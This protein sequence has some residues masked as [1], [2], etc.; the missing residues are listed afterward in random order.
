MT[1]AMY[2]TATLRGLE[3]DQLVEL[4]KAHEQQA[5][6]LRAAAARRAEE[7][8]M[9]RATRAHFDTLAAAPALVDKYERQGSDRA[10]AIA[11]TALQLDVPGATV[12]AYLLKRERV[13]QERRKGDCEGTVMQLVSDGHSNAE[14]ARR[15]GAHPGTVARIVQRLIRH[16][17]MA[18]E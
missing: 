10:T 14:I 3:P 6:V 12:A 5:A 2:A 1:V 7:I 16:R 15:V 13:K 9:A 8:G 18:A 17:Q 11:C 4:A